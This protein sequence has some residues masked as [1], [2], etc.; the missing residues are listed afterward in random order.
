M[1][2]VISLVFIFLTRLLLPSKLSIVEVLRKRYGDR[3]LKL[4]R[5]FEKTNVKHKKALLDLQF[6]KVCEDHN[7]IAN[8]WRFKVTNAS[9]RTSSTYK[10]F[11][12]KLLREEI[13]N[14]KLLVRQLDR[15]SNLTY[16]N[17][18][19]DLNIID[20]HH[21]LNTSLMSNEKEL[22]RF[23]FRNLSKIKNLIPNFSWDMV[24]TSSH[25]QEVIFLWTNF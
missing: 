14:K 18:K 23:K 12:K 7:V 13:Y 6:L 10:R 17:V 1:L 3:I 24:L 25:D 11:Q 5:K 2:F 21:V 15:D 4:V 8:F 9:L 20:L 19:S 22:G 16:K